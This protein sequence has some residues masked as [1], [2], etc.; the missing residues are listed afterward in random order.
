ME[1]LCFSRLQSAAVAVFNQNASSLLNK[2]NSLGTEQPKYR[3]FNLL[4]SAYSDH[5]NRDFFFFFFNFIVQIDAF[6]N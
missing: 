6:R 3:K 1:V 5:N 2:L 4:A